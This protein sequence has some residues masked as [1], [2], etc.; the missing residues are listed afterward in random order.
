MIEKEIRKVVAMGGNLGI[1]FPAAWCRE[2]NV[3][4]GDLMR[5]KESHGKL[6]LEKVEQ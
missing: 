1:F 4:K 2:H 3:N 5:M 6:I